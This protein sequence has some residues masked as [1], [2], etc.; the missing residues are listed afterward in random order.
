M[1]YLHMPD[2]EVGVEVTGDR[3]AARRFTT[4]FNLPKRIG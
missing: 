2:S 1:V 4:L 3:E